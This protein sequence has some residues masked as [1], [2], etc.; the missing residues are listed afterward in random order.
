MPERAAGI[1]LHPT[2]LPGRF[3]VGDLGPAADRFLDWLVQA[4]Q[5][6][7]QILPLG[8]PEVH[9]SPYNCLSAFAGNPLLISPERLLE[10]GLLDSSDI[11]DLAVAS[12]GCVDFAAVA[13]WKEPLLRRS[14]E[15]FRG[16]GRL[17]D[18]AAAFEAA[19]EQ[20]WL[21]DWTLFAALRHHYESR[22]WWDWDPELSRR[23]PA[24]LDEARRRLADEVAF[25]GY[26]QFQFFRQWDRVRAE[27][28]NRGVRILGDLP[29]YV[30]QNSAEVWARPELFDLDDAGRP[31]SVAGV[32]PDYF[33]ETGQ[34]WGNP[35][36]R[37]DR[38]ADDGYG[39][40]IARLAVNLRLA[41]RVRL[42]HFRAFASYWKV[43]A[44]DETAAGGEWVDGPRL[45][46]F[47]AFREA[48][49][50]LPLIAEDLG[51]ITP[52]VEELLAAL[53]LPGMRVL[54]FG[55]DD[56]ESLHAVHNLPP[57]CVVYSGT[58]DNDTTTG[59]YG[60]LEPGT[61]EWVRDYC[62]LGPDADGSDVARAM[63]RL[64]YT[65]AAEL[66]VVPVQDVLGLGS[67]ARM[68]TPA[69]SGGNWLWRLREGELRREHAERLARLA[70]ISGRRPY[71]PA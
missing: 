63:I 60:D 7:W 26:V 47:D 41:D 13:A 46:L 24:A 21:A 2:S 50:D 30:A 67:A 23:R 45:P 16:S 6:W 71:S 39:W 28:R 56:S 51:E 40:W 5:A 22:G 64:A 68:N 48:L 62:G 15:R 1:L 54:Q 69:V 44:G 25:H 49:G 12:P 55:F 9:D 19:P 43:P 10:D 57:H 31:L 61:R 32:P 3:G 42:D 65:S 38:M 58:H 18:E 27:G 34:L 52:D 37:W 59:W 29:I 14:W 17:R 35:L 33:S 70:E 66:A 4:G 20:A 8:P 36:Y 11:D 53:G